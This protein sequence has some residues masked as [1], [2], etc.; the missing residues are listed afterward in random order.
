MRALHTIVL[1]LLA[2]MFLEN[3]MHA[4]DVKSQQ[5]LSRRELVSGLFGSVGNTPLYRLKRILNSLPSS[6]E[7][8][9]KAE[10]FNP[11]GSI[12]DRPAAGILR[13]AL[14]DGQLHEGKTFL[15]ST[16]GNMGIAYATLG[17]SLGIPLHLT[18]PANAG[19]N[20]I[21]ILRTLG[22]EVTLTDPLEGSD[23][24]RNVAA[25]MAAHRPHEFYYADQYSHPANWQAH[26]DTTGP[27]IISQ[28]SGRIS[29]FV[30]GL[31]TTGTIMGT[32]RYLKNL[33]PDIQLVAVQP[34]GPMH[35]LEGL[36]HIPSSDVPPIFD[37]SFLDE[38][39]AIKT[40]DAYEMARSMAHEEGLLIGISAA[41]AAVA[42][43]EIAAR[44]DSGVIVVIFPDSGEKYL[45]QPFWRDV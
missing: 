4:I 43:L 29:H 34:D 2:V 25:D 21:S 16:S 42:A 35:G 12:K 40:T 27:E 3:T 41:A 11:G 19:E 20:R 36:K 5:V 6:V 7:V 44:L 18:V 23:G 38:T 17:A 45:Q 8:Y 39:I 9:G 32:G 22:A 13:H 14:A 37:P 30:A 28:T 33:S 1:R 24:A 10:W 15:D 26:Y 31:G